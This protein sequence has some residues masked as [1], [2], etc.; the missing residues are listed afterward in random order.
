[1]KTYVLYHGNCPDG[2]GA[3][4]V[5]WKKYKDSAKYIPV[6]HG[7]PPPDMNDNS[8]VF[9]V[10]F[11]YDKKT[12]LDLEK[13][14]SKI[15]LIDHHKTAQNDLVDIDFAIF[16]MER[17]G[18]VLAWLYL[19]EQEPIPKFLEYVEDRDLWTFKLPKSQQIHAYMSNIPFDF[20]K[21]SELK[22]SIE[23]NFK[24]CAE[25]GNDLLIHDNNSV[26]DICKN[27]RIVDFA[28]FQVP[29]VNSPI[30][31]SEIGNYLALKFTKAKFALSWYQLPDGN[32]KVSLRSRK[33]FDVT[34]IAK[35]FGGG[36]HPQASGCK[37][38]FIP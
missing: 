29:S 21:W 26:E 10:D 38:D 25:I 35:Q 16:N 24:N 18:A 2:F 3:A 7:N 8:E 6:S 28:G 33:D 31:N 9:I 12:L 27:V 23:N 5:F 30:L 1:M 13:K 36:G 20:E 14:H 19:F 22:E 34:P 17:S 37:I 4:W 15:T 32:F 11:S